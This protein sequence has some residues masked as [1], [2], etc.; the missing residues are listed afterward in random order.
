[1][2]LTDEEKRQ[3]YNAHPEEFMTPA[4][5]TL[6]EI[7][8]H[9]P[10]EPRERPARLSTSRPDEA[11]KDK[12]DDGARA[13]ARRARTSPSSSARCPSPDRRPTAA[14]SGRR[15]RRAI[16]PTLADVLDEAEARR[17]HRAD[18]Q[19]HGL[20]DLQARNAQ[21]GRAP[22]RSTR[23]ATQIAQKIYESRL[24]GE[25]KKFLEKLR[26]QALIEWK[27]DGYKQMYDK[28][29]APKA[30]SGCWP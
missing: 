16:C 26:T 30:G 25:T 13:R 11:A 6:R 19:R 3:Y 18:S 24:E 9:V 14:S 10:T 23:C 1:M 7:F 21:R 5:V 12:I 4:T 27:D 28:A 8:V 2:T 22:S 17:D 15:Q 29:R 20:P